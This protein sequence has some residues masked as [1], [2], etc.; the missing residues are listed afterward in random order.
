MFCKVETEKKKKGSAG[1][2][3]EK[4]RMKHNIVISLRKRRRR[5]LQEKIGVGSSLAE[6][7]HTREEV[8][9]KRSGTMVMARKCRD[10]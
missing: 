8:V 1:R 6:L 2:Q 3:Q 7:R 5:I 4:R 9:E 10:A